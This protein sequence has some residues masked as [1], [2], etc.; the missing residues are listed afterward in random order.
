MPG[1]VISIIGRTLETFD[2]DNRIPVYY[3]GTHISLRSYH[4]MCGAD[5]VCTL[6]AAALTII[7][8]DQKTTNKRVLPFNDDERPCQGLKEVLK[9]YNE[10]TP[11]IRLASPTSFAPVIKK[12]V[13]IVKQNGEYHILLIITDGEGA[14]LVLAPF[15]PAPAVLASFAMALAAPILL[16]DNSACSL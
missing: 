4:S 10:I 3:F 5:V 2:D 1:Q 6:L 9:R 13:Q 15:A 11:S 12:A 8:G 7:A 14:M 16:S